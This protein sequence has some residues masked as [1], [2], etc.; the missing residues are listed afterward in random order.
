MKKVALLTAVVTATWLA[1]CGGGE[2]HARETEELPTV[3]VSAVTAE[4]AQWP[5]VYEAVGTVQARVAAT[6]SAKVMGYVREV[7]G[8]HGRSGPHRRSTHDHRLSRSRGGPPGGPGGLERGQERDVA[9]VDSA[10]AAAKAQFELARATYKRMKDLH[11]KNSIT[12]QEFDEASAKLRMAE[13]NLEMAQSKK[14]QL[15]EKIQQAQ[16]GVASAADHEGLRPDH[17]AV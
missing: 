8:E 3:T 9:E 1:A 10:I 12:E 4:Q 7:S 11:E 5:V 17:G 2:Q 13:A 16:E 14:S 6:V 15:G